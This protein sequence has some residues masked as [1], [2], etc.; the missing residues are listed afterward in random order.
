MVKNRLFLSNIYR[1]NVGVL[2]TVLVLLLQE[3]TIVLL[4]FILPIMGWNINT[5]LKL[6]YFHSFVIKFNVITCS[7][8]NFRTLNITTDSPTEQQIIITQNN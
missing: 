7:V 8:C 2:I 6:K 1:A 5:N 3:L 4:T